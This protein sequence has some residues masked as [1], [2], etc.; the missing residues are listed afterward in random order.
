MSC[1]AE[2]AQRLEATSLNTDLK[3]RG[4]A[5]YK[6]KKYAEAEQLYSEALA[7]DRHSP[8]L[9]LNRAAARLA[10]KRWKWAYRDTVTALELLESAQDVA[11]Q[12]KAHFRR[13]KAEEALRLW[14][15]AL[16]S[17]KSALA[18]SPDSNEIKKCVKRLEK[19]VA[20]AT[21]GSYDWLEVFQ[22]GLDKSPSARLDMADFVGPFEVVHMTERGGGRGVRATRDIA[23]GELILVEQAFA[24]QHPADVGPFGVDPALHDQIADILARDGSLSGVL[25]SLYAGPG[26]PTPMRPPA[27]FE[28]DPMS[29]TSATVNRSRIAGICTYNWLVLGFLAA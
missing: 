17:Y 20:E 3:D 21:L 10:L 29:D 26:S 23:P 9:H 1:S 5:A 15:P 27:R 13:A 8:L 2:L 7:Q 24:T 11:L 6:A 12:G 18:L 4:N 16:D 25:L 28:C 14:E 22:R 19:R